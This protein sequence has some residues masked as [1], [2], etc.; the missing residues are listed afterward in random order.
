VSTAGYVKLLL[1]PRQS[2]GNSHVGLDDVKTGG[3]HFLRDQ[4]G[5]CPETAQATSGM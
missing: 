4:F 1:P 3:W 2:R 5:G